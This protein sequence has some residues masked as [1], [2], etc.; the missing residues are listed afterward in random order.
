MHSIPQGADIEKRQIAKNIISGNR[1]LFRILF[2]MPNGDTYL[3]EPYS[4]QMIATVHNYAF[5][6]YYQWA[7]KTNDTFLGNVIVTATADVRG[8]VIAVP[9]YSLIDNSTIVGLWAGV[10]DFN[11]L[12]TS[13]TQHYCFR[14]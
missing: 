10:I 6:D 1:D 5:R 7:I 4:T 11:V 2:I 14:R 13:I 8:A 9:V 12:R 3:V